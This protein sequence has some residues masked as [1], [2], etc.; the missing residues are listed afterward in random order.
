M[1]RFLITKKG[2]RWKSDTLNKK[3]KKQQLS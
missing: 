1:L 3:T 2:K